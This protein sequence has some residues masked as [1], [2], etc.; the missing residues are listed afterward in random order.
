MPSSIVVRHNDRTVTF[1]EADHSYI[2]DKMQRYVSVTT[3]V[4]MGFE[5]FDAEATAKRK[6][7]KDGGDLKAYVEAWKKTGEQA[8]NF[9]TRLHYNCEQ[10]ILGNTDKILTP[11]NAMEKIN[12]DL[13]HREVDRIVNEEKDASLQPEKLV[14]SEKLH[15]AGSIDLLVE[16]SNGTYKIYD[17]KN[18]KGISTVGYKGKTGILDCTKD[19]QDSNYW[20][21]ALQ[22]QLY[23]II[24]KVEGYVPRDAHFFRCLN[25]FSNGRLTHVEMP[26][27]MKEAKELIKW[28][29]RNFHR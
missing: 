17:W 24:L 7:E 28:H 14:F 21:Y 13:A 8:A 4:G 5:K 12:F 1:N 15:L 11:V 23:E 25:V 18:V 19:M 3:L 16:S 27:V 22:L 20:H 2:D 26:D 29:C 6:A 9:G 10:Q